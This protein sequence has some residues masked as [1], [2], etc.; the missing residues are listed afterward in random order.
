[1]FSENCYSSGESCTIKTWPEYPQENFCVSGIIKSSCNRKTKISSSIN[2]SNVVSS[3]D[4]IHNKDDCHDNQ[5]KGGSDAKNN[6]EWDQNS[7]SSKVSRYE[8]THIDIMSLVSK[9]SP[10]GILNKGLKISYSLFVLH[11]KYMIFASESF[12]CRKSYCPLLIK[13]LCNIRSFVMIL[14]T[15]DLWEKILDVVPDF[16]IREFDN[17]I[18]LLHQW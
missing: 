12:S 14:Q 13:T 18:Q 16:L 17:I 15:A 10:P 1:M 11:M 7:C 3:N 8:W 9:N 6:S 5:L 2:S 4:F